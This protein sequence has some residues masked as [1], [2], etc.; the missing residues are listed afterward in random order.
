MHTIG[1]T[2]KRCHPELVEGSDTFP[3]VCG[4]VALSL[5]HTERAEDVCLILQQAQDDA[6][7]YGS[8]PKKR[9]ARALSS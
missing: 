2:K 1:L 9:Y 5:I 3:V 6:S 4:D 8:Y 7:F